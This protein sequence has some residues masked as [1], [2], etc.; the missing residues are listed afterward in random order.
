MKKTAPLLD[1]LIR[2]AQ[3]E[4]VVTDKACIDTLLR[5]YNELSFIETCGDDDLRSIWIEIPRGSIEDFGDYEEFLEEEM[6]RNYEDFV[7]LWHDDYPEETKWYMFSI[8]TYKNE[9]YFFFDSVLT[10]HVKLSEEVADRVYF[11][12]DLIG[13]LNE[14]VLDTL[15]GIKTDVG[16]YNAHLN[17]HLPFNRRFG[18]LFR[19]DYWSIFPEEGLTFQ[20]NLSSEDISILEAVVNQSIGSELNLTLKNMTA[21][22]FFEY[23]RIGYIAN[24]YFK[25]E[26]SN[27][28][29]LEMYKRK[30]D[31]RDD[32]MTK[33]DFDSEEDF[34]DWMKHKMCGGHPWE[35]CRGGNST[36]ISLYAY[37][38]ENGWKLNLAGSS[39]V[40]VLETVKMAI[41][42]YKNHIPFTLR[43]AEE[44]LRMISGTDYIG[45][46]PKTIFPRY[47]S[48]HF[49][50]EDKII[51]F[52]NLGYE[53]KKD[54]IE[55]AIW[56]PIREIRIINP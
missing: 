25:D 7:E 30:A 22:D 52:M 46:V 20:S 6:V 5:Q 28:S 27:L 8:M 51:D 39:C 9:Y 35:I 34:K 50:S 55:K 37:S 33:L 15:N 14:I 43:D 18:K 48:S 44:I 17:S 11:S 2:V 41:A 53:K 31:G 24:D 1:H 36:H 32:G 45:I 49:P 13:W 54:I 10:F 3:S 26:K 4:K 19:K 21:G 47:C 56:Y 12:K 16:G 40:R 23:C 42:L 29:A 38:I